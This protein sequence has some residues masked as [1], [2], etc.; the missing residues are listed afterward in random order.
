MKLEWIIYSILSIIG[1]YVLFRTLSW[2]IFKSWFE[3]NKLYKTN[4]ED[5][6]GNENG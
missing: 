5:K 4:K 3:L 6:N 2:A 1:S